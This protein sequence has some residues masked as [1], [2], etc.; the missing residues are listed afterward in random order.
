MQR[1]DQAAE[2]V[3]ADLLRSELAL[4]AALQLVEAGVPVEPLEDVV[5]LCCIPLPGSGSS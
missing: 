3:E 4:E 2:L 1:A 5:F